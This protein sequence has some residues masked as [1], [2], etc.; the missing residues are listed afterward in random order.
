V[1]HALGYRAARGADHVVATGLPN[2]LRGRDPDELVERL[3]AGAFDGGATDVPTAQDELHALELM[4]ER[5]RPADVVGLTALGQRPEV[6]ARLDE[7]GAEVADPATVRRL[8]RRA[9]R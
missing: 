6:F 9:R 2:Y 5:S 1:L 7:L 8:V 3:R 4:L